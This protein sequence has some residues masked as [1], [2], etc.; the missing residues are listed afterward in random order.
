[1]TKSSDKSEKVGITAADFMAEARALTLEGMRKR[2]AGNRPSALDRLNELL[3]QKPNIGKDEARQVAQP[4]LVAPVET[5]P[6]Q[7][8]KPAPLS[9]DEAIAAALAES[10]ARKEWLAAEI[11]E[12]KARDAK[13]SALSPD[14]A[15]M[16]RKRMGLPPRS[17]APKPLTP[18]RGVSVPIPP[19]TPASAAPEPASTPAVVVAA[20]TPAPSA[21]A[22]AVSRP[23]PVAPPAESKEARQASRY[24][25]CISAGLP[26]PTDTYASLP[27]GIGKLAKDEGITRQ[28]F[29]EDVKAHIGRLHG[30]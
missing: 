18:V 8:V 23:E 11:E 22:P 13:L 5:I 20:S 26:M 10:E 24:Q 30:R 28:A 2:A 3:G 19:R 1:M 29:A 12:C 15:N 21:S 17:N 4:Q 14:V 7:S 9:P 16:A 27:R 25:A 6:T